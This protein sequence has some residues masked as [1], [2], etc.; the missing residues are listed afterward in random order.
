MADAAVEEKKR[1][2]RF[3]GFFPTGNP[4]DVIALSVSVPEA[5][6]PLRCLAGPVGL[7]Q[8]NKSRIPLIEQMA[9][10]GPVDVTGSGSPWTALNCTDH[11]YPWR[12][13]IPV[14][15]LPSRGLGAVCD[16]RCPLTLTSSAER[17][18]LPANGRTGETLQSRPGRSW[19]SGSMPRDYLRFNRESRRRARR[20]LSRKASSGG[21]TAPIPSILR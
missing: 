21:E 15:P 8:Y 11:S 6:R 17:T 7:R 2:A 14:A 13:S 1:S 16:S 12:A 3:L 9:R 18:L 19:L 4:L 20:P 10:V 5:A